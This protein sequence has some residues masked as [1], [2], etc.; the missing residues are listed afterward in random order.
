MLVFYSSA[1]GNTRKFIETLGLRCL[2]IEKETKI[3]EP[4]VL[5]TPTFADGEGR[6]AV[7][8]P[9]IRFLND[10]QNRA[11]IRGVI[12]GGNRNFGDTFGLAGRVISKK[13]GVPHLYS[14][15]LA[16]TIR[17]SHI[18]KDGLRAFWEREKMGDFT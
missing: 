14:F 10:P 16:G 6:G 11:H 4:F 17:D 2:E 1:T 8:K 18:V 15:E 3:S 13:C 7:P 5:V 9:V 12:S